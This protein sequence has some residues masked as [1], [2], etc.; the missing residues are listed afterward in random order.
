MAKMLELIKPGDVLLVEFMQPLGI[1]QNQLAR[2]IDVPPS[3]INAIIHGRR[4]ITADMALRLGKYFKTSAVIWLN[5]QVHYD[6][7]QAERS[8]WPK[9][10]P[11]IRML[12]EDS[13]T[14]K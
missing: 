4:A 11:R 9:I 12:P 8:I 14:T 10:S 13:Y 5:L 3:R 2:D 7:E 1:S 6:I